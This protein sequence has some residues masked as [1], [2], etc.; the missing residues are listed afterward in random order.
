MLESFFHLPS[1]QAAFSVLLTHNLLHK[2]PTEH[3]QRRVQT[4][5]GLNSYEWWNSTIRLSDSTGNRR[6]GIAVTVQGNSIADRIFEAIAL[7]P[8]NDSLRNCFLARLVKEIIRTD[9]IAG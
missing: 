3:L 1:R 5:V 6:Q 2:I 7:Q 8:G 9:F 4:P